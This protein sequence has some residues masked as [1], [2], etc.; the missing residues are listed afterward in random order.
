ML[1]TVLSRFSRRKVTYAEPYINLFGRGTQSY[2]FNH[3]VIDEIVP[4]INAVYRTLARHQ[5]STM[6]GLM[7]QKSYHG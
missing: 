4:K 1:F 7:G 3:F 2:A 6:M 5:N